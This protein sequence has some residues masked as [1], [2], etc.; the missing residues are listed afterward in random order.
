MISLSK[1]VSQLLLLTHWKKL[2]GRFDNNIH[3]NRVKIFLFFPLQK[4]RSFSPKHGESSVT[5]T[6]EGG[7]VHLNYTLR[8]NP[9]PM[10]HNT[11]SHILYFAGWSC[12][13][14]QVLHKRGTDAQ[15]TAILQSRHS[16]KP[17]ILYMLTRTQKSQ[18]VSKTIFRIFIL[19]HTVA[20]EVLWKCSNTTVTIFNN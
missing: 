12:L 1:K 6:E 8:T 10:S 18:P 20:K 2:S 15:S 7:A 5:V 11:K 19:K 9:P 14:L 16:L 3:P 17:S 13:H 4:L